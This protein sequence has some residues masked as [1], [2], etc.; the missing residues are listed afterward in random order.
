MDCFDRFC[1]LFQNSFSF[2]FFFP[3]LKGEG[4]KNVPVF[5][6]KITKIYFVSIAQDVG[7]R[8][9]DLIIVCAR[10]YSPGPNSQR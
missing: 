3:A 8:K 7:H 10:G 5:S 9:P 1:N 6:F 4:A 2:Q